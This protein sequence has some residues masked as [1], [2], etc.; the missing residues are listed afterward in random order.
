MDSNHRRLAPADLQSAPIGHSGNCPKTDQIIITQR[1][2][3]V[4]LNLTGDTKWYIIMLFLG[5][6]P[7]GK[8]TD[9]D[10][11][12]RWFKSSRPCQQQSNFLHKCGGEY[13]TNK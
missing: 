10:S 4:N 2:E 1:G 5:A 12:M 13:A 8:A 3:V 7:S 6:S 9:F 11:V